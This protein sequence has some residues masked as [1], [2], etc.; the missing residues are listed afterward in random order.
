MQC[1]KCN[2]P[3]PVAN[4]QPAGAKNPLRRN[5][6][7]C[8]ATD[9]HK[10]RTLAILN[11]KPPPGDAIKPETQ[12]KI[13]AA[14][15]FKQKFDSLRGTDKVA[16]YLTE[17]RKR[18]TESKQTKRTFADT[19]AFTIHQSGDSKL[20]DDKDDYETFEDWA[21]RQ[22]GLKRCAN[23]T[24]AAEKWELE[25]AKPGARVTERRG[26]VLLGRFA[27]V[28]LTN[29]HEEG[30]ITGFKG[31]NNVDSKEDMEAAQSHMEDARLKFRKT[32]ELLNARAKCEASSAGG[33]KISQVDCPVGE[34]DLNPKNNSGMQ[35]VQRELAKKAE[36]QAVQDAIFQDQ[37]DEAVV[38]EAEKK[39][40]AERVASVEKLNLESSTSKMASV[41]MDS[42]LKYR[43]QAEVVNQWAFVLK[44]G[45]ESAKLDDF[46]NE[47]KQKTDDFTAAAKKMSERAEAITKEFNDFA[48]DDANTAEALF[49]KAGTIPQLTKRFF[50]EDNAV[51]DTKDALKKL[52][53][54]KDQCAKALKKQEAEEAKQ[55]ARK[56]AVQV[57]SG[58][59]TE[60][61]QDQM[62]KEIKS[63]AHWV[64]NNINANWI[65]DKVFQEPPIPAFVPKER[66]ESVV[67]DLKKIDYFNSQKSWVA[68]A[69]KKQNFEYTSACIVK[70][71][72][73]ATVEKALVK[74]GQPMHPGGRTG[75]GKK[76]VEGLQQPTFYQGKTGGVYVAPGTDYGM[77]DTRLNLDGAEMIFLIK[78]E[79]V[80]G[81]D[82]RA[83][84]AAVCSMSP[85]DLV[86]AATDHGSYYYLTNGSMVI[87]PTGFMVVIINTSD[88]HAVHG[89]RWLSIG[90]KVNAAKT[91][92]VLEGLTASD[93]NTEAAEELLQA[94]QDDIAADTFAEGVP[95]AA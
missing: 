37:V 68:A 53:D 27:G 85:K 80:A 42:V 12:E 21:V 46:D 67:E 83:K 19:K 17:K 94:I 64:A 73:V 95:T 36:A 39:Q 52:R 47:L 10:K 20:T 25:I 38:R 35:N 32:S 78:S 41:L 93:E 77:I 43:Q 70:A 23:E 56:S 61:L 65:V 79:A 8:C 14:K 33:A 5:C 16:W 11:Y 74:L 6:N 62:M 66:V 69:M 60:A 45:G 76:I 63:N 4:S 13:N 3:V 92:E 31:S 84:I 44:Q 18:E 24:E 89:I 15:A 22:I 2:E 9:Q 1:L 88:D 82:V 58:I 48:G 54:Y 86:K 51:K 71:A 28:G 59:S 30:C 49:N 40:S 90:S 55:K 87:I 50:T 75:A 26:Q 72:A 7:E 91:V 34:E 29:R 81:E 57:G